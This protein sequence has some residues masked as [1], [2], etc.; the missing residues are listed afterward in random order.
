MTLGSAK[1]LFLPLL[2]LVACQPAR[3]PA[4]SPGPASPATTGAPATPPAATPAPGGAAAPTPKSGSAKAPREDASPGPEAKIGVLAPFSGPYAGHGRAYL[5]GVNL[6]VEA[7]QTAGGKAVSVVPADD[8]ALPEGALIAVRRLDEAEKVNCIVGG[9]V[10]GPTWVA[11]LECNWR[12]VPFLA[13]VAHEPELGSIGPWI[14]HEGA[15][16][17]RTAQAAAELA[18]FELRLFRAALL[19]PQEGEGRLQASEFS[20]RI[21]ALG[22][23]IVASEAFAPGTTDFT[24]P[25]RRLAGANPDVLYLPIDTETMRLVLPALVVEGLEARLIGVAAWNSSRF[26]SQCGGDLEGALVP[27][28]ELGG[29]DRAAL[30]RFESA[31]RA[32]HGEAPSRFA[33]AGYIAGQR[34]L[35]AMAARGSE[36]AALQAELAARTA[37]RRAQTTAPR[38]LVVKQGALKSFPTP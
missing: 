12:G 16:P 9:F 14:F 24:A 37:A 20:A 32:R 34:V 11:A 15:P 7:A 23:R 18:T 13:N 22:G 29:E 31:Y 8:K 30:G 3:V 36:R 5:D 25:V 1:L 4:P 10:G 2:W 28:T 21:A 27:D 35:E 19:F 17:A 6:A 33:A 38:F 26:L